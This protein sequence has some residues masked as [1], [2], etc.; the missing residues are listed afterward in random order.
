M[1]NRTITA[2][3]INPQSPDDYFT[4]TG[5]TI[6]G[7][8]GV[9]ELVYDDTQFTAAESKTRLILAVEHL[10]DYLKETNDTWPLS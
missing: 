7:A 9:V 1:A 8:S 3:K 5:G 10:L 6:T 2:A 4:G